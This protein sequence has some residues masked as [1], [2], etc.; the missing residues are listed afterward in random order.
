MKFLN[1]NKMK[2][3]HRK[4]SLNLPMDLAEEANNKGSNNRRGG[5]CSGNMPQLRGDKRLSGLGDDGIFK[6][7]FHPRDGKERHL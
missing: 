5:Y 4:N 7:L 6:H 1:K 3:I 2:Q